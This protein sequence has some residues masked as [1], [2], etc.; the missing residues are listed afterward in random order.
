MNEPFKL[1]D[2]DRRILDVLQTDA[3]LSNQEVADQVASSA[4]SVWRRIRAMEDAGVILGFRA[5]VDPEKLGL[6]E[7]VLVNISLDRH[8]VQSSEAFTDRILKTPSVLEC[9][10]GTGDHDFM[11]KVIV[12]D[13]RAY[14]DF[15]EEDLMEGGQIS[16]TSSTVVMRKIKETTRVGSS[17]IPRQT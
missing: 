17:I 8:N 3:R 4:S 6:H 14:F 5:I 15:L 13:M 9:Y 11:L 12:P 10:V 2:L 1:T 7:T 16:R